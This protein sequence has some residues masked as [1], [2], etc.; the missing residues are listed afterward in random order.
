VRIGR[1]RLLVKVVPV[2]PANDES[3][4][5]NG[6]E[7]GRPSPDHCLDSAAAY[8]EEASISL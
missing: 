1:T 4:V 3:E 8:G 6:R 7:R 2:I 5:G